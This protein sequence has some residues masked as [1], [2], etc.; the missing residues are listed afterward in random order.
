MSVSVCVCVSVARKITVFFVNI[1]LKTH[2]E[3]VEFTVGGE[4]RCQCSLL[5]RRP[6]LFERLILTRVVLFCHQEVWFG[7]YIGRVRLGDGGKS[8]KSVM[9]PV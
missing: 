8:D 5:N 9:A 6:T 2:H 1:C 4:N 3:G 7:G